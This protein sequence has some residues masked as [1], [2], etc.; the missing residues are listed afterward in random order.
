LLE[1]GSELDAARADLL[2]EVVSKL[3]KEPPMSL[4]GLKQKHLDLL[5]KSL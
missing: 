2:A 4:I 5:A 1:N 3:R